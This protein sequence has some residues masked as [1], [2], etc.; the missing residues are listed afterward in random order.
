V[1][2]II[3]SIDFLKPLEKVFLYHLKN[4][5]KMI[6]NDGFVKAP[7]IAD[8]KY[9]IVL[10][11]SHR[12]VF[13]LMNGYKEVPVKFVNYEDEHIRVGARLIHRHLI[14]ETLH[15]SKKDIIKR[16]LS[17]DLFPPRTT[18]HFFPF[19]KNER[20]NLSL[21]SLKK[22]KDVDVSHF[23]ADST[24][25][26]EIDHNKQYLSE[27]ENEFDELIRY[28]EEVRQTKNYLKTQVQMMEVKPR[29]VAFF[30]GKFQPVHM[31]HI[32]SIMKI[33]DD[34]EKIIIGITSDSPN[35]LSL[36]ERKNIFKSV[37]SRYKKFEYVFFDTSLVDIVDI[38]VL[39]QFDVCV[40][41]N[42]KVIDFM[43]KYNFKTRFLNRSKGI[44]Y[45]GT[46]I[47]SI[48]GKKQ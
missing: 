12:Y 30:P 35:I 6:L 26:D 37:L 17:G 28:M 45:S 38:S 24:L 7:I 42:Q 25:Q 19:R 47:R 29:S 23:I 20:I 21:D 40:S 1:K 44:G 36:N 33:F 15:I 41:G 22:G 34:Y 11:G 4:L 3:T 13:F 9:G 2:N 14:D 32:A 18:R 5:S 16:S 43:K 27:I 48:V 10:D 39:P 31:G 8:K 46:E